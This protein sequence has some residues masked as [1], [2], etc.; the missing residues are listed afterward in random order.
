[1]PLIDKAQV[2]NWIETLPE[3][4]WLWSHYRQCHILPLM[5]KTGGMKKTDTDQR[6]H[7]NTKLLWTDIVPDF[8]RDYFEKYIFTWTKT[9]GRITVIKTSAK[10]E[11]PVHIDCSPSTFNMTQHKFRIVVQGNSDSL[12]FETSNGKVW[13]PKTEKP[14]IMDGSWPHGMKN[15]CPFPKYTLGLGSPCVLNLPPPPPPFF[16]K[17]IKC[18]KISK[19]SFK[20][21]KT[22]IPV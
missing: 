16:W 11:N 21:A 19:K 18:V 2:V 10:G 17:E 7:S 5:T 13:A 9:R 22:F 20:E 3:N 4:L 6:N 12:Y 1:M 14:F 15:N 8:I